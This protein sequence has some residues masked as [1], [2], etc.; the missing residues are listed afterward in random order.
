[1][2]TREVARSLRP[3]IL[4]HGKPDASL[5]KYRLVAVV[6]LFVCAV[7]CLSSCRN[8]IIVGWLNGP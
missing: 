1:M 5:A 3:M 7:Q 8:T 2:P 4:T 6:K